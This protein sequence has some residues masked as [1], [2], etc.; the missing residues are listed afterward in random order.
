[1]AAKHQHVEVTVTAAPLYQVQAVVAV[2]VLDLVGQVA[3][4][5][6]AHRALLLLDGN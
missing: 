4:V 3:Q 1:M 6:Q 5:E 2:V